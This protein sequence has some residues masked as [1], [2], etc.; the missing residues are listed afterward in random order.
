MA[1]YF[2]IG[3]DGKEYGPVTDADVR[4]WIAEDRLNAKSQAKSESDAEF[5]P[6]ET[7]PEF[8][9]VFAPGA[10]ADAT[11]PPV[12]EARTDDARTLALGKVKSP[13]I[14]LKVTAILNLVFGVW[15][16]VKMTFFPPDMSEF[17]TQ[18][19]RLHDPQLEALLQ[20]AMHIS[21][22]PLGI[23]SNLFGLVLSVLILMGAIKMQ[24]LRSYEFCVT[25]AILA[26]LPCLTPCC[27]IGLPI[28]L[29]ALLVLMKPEVKS[30]FH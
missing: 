28:G 22:G 15:S 1:N 26:M 5:R 8:A 13:A 4:Q 2:I 29:W 21:Y 30:Q 20:K 7:F 25:A 10:P 24:S 23:V 6:L 18:L 12:M 9:D 14:G 3:G 17:N 19:E 27:I 11:V 16:T